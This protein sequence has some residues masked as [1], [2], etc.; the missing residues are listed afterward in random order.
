MTAI[1]TLEGTQQ[2]PQME[3]GSVPELKAHSEAA[4]CPE[5]PT[6]TGQAKHG[7]NCHHCNRS[8][9]ILG[10]YL[11]IKRVSLADSDMNLQQCEVERMIY[12]Y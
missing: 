4:E 10:L 7:E 8:A 2:Q 3:G 9:W 5:Q 12:K 6:R 1:H 11:C